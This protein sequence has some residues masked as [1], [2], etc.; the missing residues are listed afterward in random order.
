MKGDKMPD[1]FI[2]YS[3]DA[4]KW[5]ERLADS[6]QREGVATWSDFG[7]LRPGERLHDQ[8]QRAL[9]Q[10]TFYVVVVGPRNLMRDSQDR[11]WQGA[12]E[13]T[14]TDPDKRIIPVLVGDAEAPAFLRNWASFRFEPGRHES[15][16][17]KK[18]AGII[19]AHGRGEQ[20]QREGDRL[21]RD[22]RKRIREMESTAKRLKSRQDPPLIKEQ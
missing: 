22:W 11:E 18:L 21:G 6:L 3:A 14:W 2:S 16:S 20:S 13:R 17:V 1:V 4:R 19:K 7:N 12:L 10:A 5:A 15:A 9:D 8:V